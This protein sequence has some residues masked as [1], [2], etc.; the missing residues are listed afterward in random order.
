MKQQSSA[1]SLIGLARS[2]FAAGCLT[3]ATVSAASAQS[4]EFMVNECSS[5]AQ[6]FFRD[7]NARTQMQYNGQR[8]DGT[9]AINGRIFL[10]TRAEDFACSYEPS[11]RRMVEFFAQGRTMP[12]PLPGGGAATQLPGNTGGDMVRVTGLSSG[13]LLNVRSGPGTG[14]RVIGKLTNGDRVRRLTCQTTG[15]STWCQIEMTTDMRE[16]GWVNARYL[17]GSGATQGGAATQLPSTPPAGAGQ[18]TTVTVRFPPGASGTELTD[19]LPPGATRRY[20]LGARAQQFLYFR[21][22][23][24]A[25]GMS[26]RILNPDSTLLDR[27]PA[28]REYRGQLWQ[29]GRHVIEVI[30]TTN[31]SQTYN[32]IFGIN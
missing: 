31:R 30:N 15:S 13:D 1:Q 7:F 3:L 24:N 25:R 8:V 32:V 11:G 4:K 22:A 29:T 6:T 12:S 19:S 10:E 5:A 9:H 16:R 14:F 26:W 2:L 20:L 28:S 21:L 17:S 18:T 27:Q 23:T